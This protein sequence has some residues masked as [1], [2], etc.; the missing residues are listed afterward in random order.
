MNYV[1][2]FVLPVPKANIEAYKAMAQKAGAIWKEYGA[3]D[4]VE[5]W[6]DD[7]QPGEVTSFPQAVQLKDD[8]VVVF[9]WI[10]YDSREHRDEVNAKVMA[11]PRIKDEMSP[12]T[13]P[14]DGM[15]MFW[16]GFKPFLQL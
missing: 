15:R 6:A 7:V 4:Y 8:E 9:A 10:T 5:C 3:L 13:M 1:D 12:D 14:F 11:D 2:G 16:G